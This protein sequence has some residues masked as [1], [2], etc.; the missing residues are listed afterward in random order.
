MV[1]ANRAVWTRHLWEGWF[2]I[3]APKDWLEEQD[4]DVILFYREQG[5]GALQI[6][7]ARRLPTSLTI[8]K[9]AERLA[10][11]F[12]EQRGWNPEQFD[13][14]TLSGSAQC[15]F[16]VVEPGAKPT[17]WEVW[18]LV[19][20]SRVVMITYNCDVGEEGV[21]RDVRHQIVSTF[22]WLPVSS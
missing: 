19:E 17:Y 10:K 13:V 4:D 14:G 2:S 11:D 6:S 18:H 20:S 12:A 3:D 21:E 7:L 9:D 15:K 16:W 1:K 8:E 22:Q 5:V